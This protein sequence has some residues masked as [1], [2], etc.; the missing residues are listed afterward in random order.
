MKYNNF[1]ELGEEY[2]KLEED[3]KY[4]EALNILEKGLEIIPR[5][6]MEKEI[7]LWLIK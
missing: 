1:D 3:E 7:V 4:E 6:E 2:Y 5:E